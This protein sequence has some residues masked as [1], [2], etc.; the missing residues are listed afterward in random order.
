MANIVEN[1]VKVPS[2]EDMLLAQTYWKLWMAMTS[3][4]RHICIPNLLWQWR[5]VQ[6]T[7]LASK[8][9]TTHTIFEKTTEVSFSW[10]RRYDVTTTPEQLTFFWHLFHLTDMPSPKFG[11]NRTIYSKVIS[12][13][14]FGT[15]A[16]F[17]NVPMTSQS[18]KSTRNRCCQLR[19][20]TNY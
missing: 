9:N 5:M 6:S 3:S 8:S 1:L 20:A 16:I 4:W 13:Q 12:I 17:E 18:V 14:S 10:P 11:W 15:F 7:F 2:I 19:T